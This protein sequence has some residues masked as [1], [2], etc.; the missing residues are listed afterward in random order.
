MLS[1][2][3]LEQLTKK[4]HKERDKKIN[5]LVKRAIEKG[6]GQE[7]INM[8][9]R[10]NFTQV[11]NTSQ[12]NINFREGLVDGT[13]RTGSGMGSKELNAPDI[14]FG[15]LEE[16]GIELPCP[17]NFFGSM[18]S[19]N[20]EKTVKDDD[21]NV[22]LFSNTAYCYTCGSFT[23]LKKIG[24]E[25]IKGEK[26]NNHKLKELVDKPVVYLFSASSKNM[27]KS[28]SKVGYSSNI[29]S[30]IKTF[31]QTAPFM[32]FNPAWVWIF[33]KETVARSAEKTALNFLQKTFKEKNKM[34]YAN[35]W[36]EEDWKTV[37]ELV[38]EGLSNDENIHHG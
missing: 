5:I 30:R 18:R 9:K 35:E 23:P 38:V 26:L 17:H 20:S 13:L 25:T 19:R 21:H 34:Q 12:D 14:N 31:S 11:W 36:F 37:K 28:L 8:I 7:Y 29:S 33:K 27:S 6:H 16:E 4:Q 1:Y 24:Y 3:P 2:T 22:V 10:F 32:D 15:A